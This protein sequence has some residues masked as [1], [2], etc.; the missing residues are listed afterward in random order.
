MMRVDGRPQP[1]IDT[2]MSV[3]QHHQQALEPDPR[4]SLLMA[5][6]LERSQQQY[7]DRLAAWEESVIEL[8]RASSAFAR[9]YSIN[10]FRT[11]SPR[12]RPPTP[13]SWRLTTHFAVL[14]L[15]CT[16][17]VALSVLG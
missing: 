10:E 12:L 5:Q 9:A 14:V 13:A 4:S 3:V 7:A 1:T 16:C 6:L 11:T 2:V 15:I 8:D 17:L